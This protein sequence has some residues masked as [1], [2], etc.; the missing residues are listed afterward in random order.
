[1]YDLIVIGAGSAGL[2]A[3]IYSAKNKVKTLVLAKEF[4][5]SDAENNNGLVAYKEIKEK[6]E[7]EI[8]KNSE[9]LELQLGQEVISLEKNIV[10]FAIEVKSGSLYYCKAVIVATGKKQSGESGTD[11]D[12]LTLKDQEGKIKTDADMKTNISGIF[13]AGGATASLFTDDLISAG[14]GAKAVISA[15]IFLKR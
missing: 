6:F 11:F 10:S 4:S 3:G 15:K 5:A 14:E 7:A 8:S 9:F 2:S 13:A 12:L 1:M